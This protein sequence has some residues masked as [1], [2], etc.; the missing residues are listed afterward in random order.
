MNA[1]SVLL[2]LASGMIAALA[3]YLRYKGSTMEG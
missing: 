1:L 2:I 3:E